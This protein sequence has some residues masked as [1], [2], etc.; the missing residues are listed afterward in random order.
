M[1]PYV[2]GLMKILTHPSLMI[3]LLIHTVHHDG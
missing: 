1:N 2:F 3:L